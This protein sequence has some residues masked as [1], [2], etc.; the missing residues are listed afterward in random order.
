MSEKENRKCTAC[1]QSLGLLVVLDCDITVYTSA[2]YQRRSL[3]RPLWGNL[4][5]WPASCLDAFSTYPIQT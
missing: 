5:L 2:P 3:R 1:K 4:I